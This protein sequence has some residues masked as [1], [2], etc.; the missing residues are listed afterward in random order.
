MTIS[1]SFAVSECYGL[2]GHS[3]KYA[4]NPEE[5]KSED[6][7]TAKETEGITNERVN[8]LRN[9]PRRHRRSRCGSGYC[10]VG[11]VDL[12]VSNF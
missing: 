3:T 2:K 8:N 11:P 1:G 6:Q 5:P 4:R 9:N 7:V 12:S 10:S